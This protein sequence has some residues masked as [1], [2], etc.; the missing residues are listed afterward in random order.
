MIFSKR[1][2]KTVGFNIFWTALAFVGLS[3]SSVEAAPANR[4]NILFIAVDEL[5][6]EL[7]CYGKIYHNPIPDPKSWNEPNHWSKKASTWTPEGRRA[8]AEHRRK[9]K[10]DG[11]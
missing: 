5:R 1:P 9:M 2:L 6:P 11:V 7:G 8:L 10:A 4:P 3:V